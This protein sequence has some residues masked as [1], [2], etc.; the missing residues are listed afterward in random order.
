MNEKPQA[1]RETIKKSAFT[2]EPVTV[3]VELDLD[4]AIALGDFILE[5]H[6]NNPAIVALGYELLK[7]CKIPLKTNA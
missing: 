2:L 6:P 7:T 1:N 4:M 5:S 3:K